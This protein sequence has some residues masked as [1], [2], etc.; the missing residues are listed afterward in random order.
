MTHQ[1][2]VVMGVL[3]VSLV[4]GMSSAQAQTAERPNTLVV[5]TDDQGYGDLGCYGATKFKTPRLG[6]SGS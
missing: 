3:F 6:G 2:L 4:S 5:F 1:L